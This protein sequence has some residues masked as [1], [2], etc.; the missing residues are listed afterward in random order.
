MFTERPYYA[1]YLLPTIM[2]VLSPRLGFSGLRSLVFGLAV[3]LIAS[4]DY[5]ARFGTVRV[6]L[7][8]L[9]S[10]AA[11]APWPALARP[12]RVDEPSPAAANTIF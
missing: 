3:Y 9:V 2:S 1:L 12:V 8:Y 6:T 5:F 7:G 11:L 10:L 4:Q